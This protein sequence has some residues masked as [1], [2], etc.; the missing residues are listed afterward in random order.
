MAD[1]FEPYLSRCIVLEAMKQL[2]MHENDYLFNVVTRPTLHYKKGWVHMLCAPHAWPASPENLVHCT[3][4][5]ISCSRHNG[6]CLGISLGKPRCCLFETE[7]DGLL[8]MDRFVLCVARQAG[9]LQLKDSG[10]SVWSISMYLCLLL[11][12]GYKSSHS[13]STAA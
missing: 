8:W 13:T 10:H 9:R 11:L 6:Y 4:H 7:D 3:V 12:E 1:F 5:M 2:F